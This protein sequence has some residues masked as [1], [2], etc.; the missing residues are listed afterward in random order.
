MP[1]GDQTG[2]MGVGRM[3]G[4]RAGYCAGFET[5]GYSNPSRWQDFKNNFR[6]PIAWG[7]GQKWRN[8]PCAANLPWWMRFS[9][10]AMPRRYQKPN[11][12][13][14]RQMLERR[15]GILREEGGTG[16]C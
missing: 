3:A 9:G 8:S 2:P 15:A 5:P 12:E 10:C 6:T 13:K 7:G 4:R 14:E 11:L 16:I 1:R